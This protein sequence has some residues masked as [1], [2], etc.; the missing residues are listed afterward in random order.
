MIMAWGIVKIPHAIINVKN[1]QKR[2]VFG[3][4]LWEK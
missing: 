2:W 1:R 4:V 3:K